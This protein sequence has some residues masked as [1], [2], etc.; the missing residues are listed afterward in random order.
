MLIKKRLQ[1]VEWLCTRTKTT[2]MPVIQLMPGN[3]KAGGSV[4]GERRL[5]QPQPEGH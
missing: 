5:Y 3:K 2:R 4:R 1:Y